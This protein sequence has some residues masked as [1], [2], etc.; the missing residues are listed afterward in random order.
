MSDVKLTPEE[1]AALKAV[2]EFAT[3]VYDSILAMTGDKKSALWGAGRVFSQA[4]GVKVVL[5][6]RPAFKESAE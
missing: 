4:L 2:T 5:T 6:E 1:E 3:G